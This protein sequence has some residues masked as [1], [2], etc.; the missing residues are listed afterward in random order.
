VIVLVAAIERDIA[1]TEL[2]LLGALYGQQHFQK[3]LAGIEHFL[4]GFLGRHGAGQQ[5]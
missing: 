1:P 5:Y 2:S 3:I 4:A